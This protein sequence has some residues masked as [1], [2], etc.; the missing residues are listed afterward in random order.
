LQLP[1]HGHAGASHRDGTIDPRLLTSMIQGCADGDGLLDL[2]ERHGPSFNFIHAS[3]ALHT[4][5]RLYIAA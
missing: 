3:C 4:A 5:A 1:G 2:L